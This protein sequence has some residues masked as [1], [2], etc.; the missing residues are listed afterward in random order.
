[1]NFQEIIKHYPQITTKIGSF[2]NY[3]RFWVDSLEDVEDIEN[4]KEPPLE[5]SKN[6]IPFLL[7]E[8]DSFYVYMFSYD[9][10]VGYYTEDC[11]NFSLVTYNEDFGHEM[12][13]PDNPDAEHL[14]VPSVPNIQTFIGLNFDVDAYREGRIIFSYEELRNFIKEWE[15]LEK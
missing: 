9:L 1:M 3:D 13:N 14:I 12:Y 4:W 5:P 6:S 11:E 7:Y 10:V 8:N 15:N 2:Y